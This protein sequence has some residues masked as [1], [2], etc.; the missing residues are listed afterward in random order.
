MHN[1]CASA[2]WPSIGFR[3][4]GVEIRCRVAAVVGCVIWINRLGSHDMAKAAKPAQPGSD[5]LKA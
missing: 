4:G 1:V 2:L 3:Q 5:R